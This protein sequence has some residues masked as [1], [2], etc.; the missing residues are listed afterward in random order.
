MGAPAPVLSHQSFHVSNHFKLLTTLIFWHLKVSFWLARIEEAT[1]HN[2]L[3]W[4]S[5]TASNAR[6]PVKR[7]QQGSAVSLP[8]EGPDDLVLFGDISGLTYAFKGKPRR[9]LT[10]PVPESVYLRLQSHP[11]GISQFFEEAVATFNGDLNALVNAAVSFVENRRIRAGVDPPR[12]A[13][14]RV[15]PS[16]FEKVQRINEALS[17]IQGMSRAKVMAG[18]INQHLEEQ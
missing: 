12:N 8:A 11:G 15:L 14:G 10:C 7:K 18:L 1:I 2:A 4:V 13:S 9:L 3:P 16:T 17:S 5:M 6:K